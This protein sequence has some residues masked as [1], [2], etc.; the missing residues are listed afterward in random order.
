MSIC[1][2]L[3]E[4][5]PAY[6]LDA[7]NDV[8]RARIEQHLPQCTHCAGAVAVYRPVADAMA[9][10]APAADPPADLKSRVLAATMPHMLRTPPA[11][12]LLAQLSAGWSNLFRAPAF[13]AMALLWAI[14]LAVWN[15]SLQNQVAQQA[16]LSHQMSTE[17]SFQRDMLNTMAYANGEP[18]KLQGTQIASRAVG[19]LYAPADETTL[20]LIV[21]DLPPL[22]SGKVY[23]FWLVDVT[24]DR[25]SGGTFTVDEQGRGWLLVHAPKPLSNYQGV[26]VTV[27]PAGGS[28][29]P[30]GEKMMEM[31][32]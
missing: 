8:D 15:I 17:I 5:Y 28:Q 11:P 21:N 7:V 20:A 12:S 16:A 25:T 23:Q 14:G 18:M 32:L 26:G 29:Q 13:S 4:L 3:Q 22:P 30:T 9:F 24:G 19:R 1:E 10:A 27:E 2:E 6:V 31:T